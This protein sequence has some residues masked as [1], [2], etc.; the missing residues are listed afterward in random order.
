MRET[1]EKHSETSQSREK[2]KVVKA[3]KSDF[4][5]NFHL[6]TDDPLKWEEERRSL[7]HELHDIS[8][9]IDTNQERLAE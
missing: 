7:R 8:D 6:P 5:V 2:E 3:K 1:D 9:A 4:K